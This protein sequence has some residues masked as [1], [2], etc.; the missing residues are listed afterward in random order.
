MDDIIAE[1]SAAASPGF[2][3]DETVDLSDR[4]DGELGYVYGDEEHEEEEEEE[5]ATVLARRRKKKKRTARSGEPRIKWA[6]QH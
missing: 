2:T 3:M 6:Y 4:M 1:G 5:P